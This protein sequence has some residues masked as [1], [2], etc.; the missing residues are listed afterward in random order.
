MWEVQSGRKC[1]TTRC[2]AASRCTNYEALAGRNAKRRRGGRRV[3]GLQFE[4]SACGQ[5]TC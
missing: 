2:A 5:V 4:R 3:S 1:R